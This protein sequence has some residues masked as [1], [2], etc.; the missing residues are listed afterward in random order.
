MVG[1]RGVLLVRRDKDPGEGLWSIPGGGVEL[2]ETQEEAVLREVREETGVDCV[3]ARFMTTADLITPD[4]SGSIE[5]HFILNHYLARALSENT[6]PEIPEAEVGWFHPDSLPD[7]I[8]NQRI[9]DLILSVRDTALKM[10]DEAGNTS[11]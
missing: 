1:K 8:V 6:R 2:G 11:E 9:V 4:S 7:D 5:F 3:V 10:M